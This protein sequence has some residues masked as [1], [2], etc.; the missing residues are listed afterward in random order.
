MRENGSQRG[1]GAKKKLNLCNLSEVRD[2]KEPWR[3]GSETDKS[4]KNIIFS[5]LID[6]SQ[7]LAGDWNYSVQSG[8]RQ[9][10]YNA[11]FCHRYKKNPTQTFLLLVSL[12][13]TLLTTSFLINLKDA[14]PTGR[15]NT[16]RFDEKNF[17]DL[18]RTNYVSFV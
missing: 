16:L 14:C 18:S 6:R 17:Y 10:L 7:Q 8:R 5:R 15:C 3:R 12:T 2:I 13:R 1:L 9:V 11:I 4:I